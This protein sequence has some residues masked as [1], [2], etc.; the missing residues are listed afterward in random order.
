M[1]RMDSS[2]EFEPRLATRRSVLG[3]ALAGAAGLAVGSLLPR[4]TLAK[5][6]DAAAPQIVHMA[7]SDSLHLFLGA[8]GN[9]VAATGPEGVLL[10]DSGL[11][12]YASPLLAAVAAVTNGRKVDVLL[13]THWH[14]DHTGGNEALGRAGAKIIA[15]RTPDC[16]WAPRSI[17]NGSIASIRRSRRARSPPRHSST[18]RRKSATAARISSTPSCRRRIPTAMSTCS[19]RAKMCWWPAGS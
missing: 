2:L 14:W 1:T 6:A 16:G 3:G 15:T 5:A 7:L 11:A 9:V 19:F 4:L 10:V 8:G 17:R 13:N 18:G 12:A